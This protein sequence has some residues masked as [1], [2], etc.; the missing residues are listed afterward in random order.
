ME[1]SVSSV[2]SD[3][4][5]FQ[6]CLWLGLISNRC[7]YLSTISFMFGRILRNVNTRGIQFPLA[8]SDFGVSNAFLSIVDWFPYDFDWADLWWK[9]F[10][11]SIGFEYMLL[12][13]YFVPYSCMLF[14][15]FS[16]IVIFR[17]VENIFSDCALAKSAKIISSLNQSKITK[18]QW[19]YNEKSVTT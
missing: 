14:R 4:F 5:F 6:K 3:R 16:T 17:F 7:Q 13:V 19:K 18:E 15:F 8:L 9:Q 11:R 10:L 12:I 1:I 2:G